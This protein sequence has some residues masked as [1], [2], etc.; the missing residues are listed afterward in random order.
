MAIIKEIDG[1]VK[2]VHNL[3]ETVSV[4]S[5]AVT[6]FLV[7]PA[8]GEITRIR[9]QVGTTLTCFKF[10]LAQ[11]DV[12]SS[13]IDGS[14]VIADYRVDEANLTLDSSSTKYVLTESP[15]DLYYFGVDAVTGKSENF[16]KLYYRIVTD[17]A[18]TST[19]VIDIDI[20]AVA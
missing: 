20:E 11:E 4:S 12:F 17:N 16:K 1:M 3:T 15:E 18:A 14:K 5:T 2:V 6:G 10:T 9:V 7:V 19:A 8:E 13:A